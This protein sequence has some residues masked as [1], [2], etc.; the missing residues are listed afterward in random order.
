MKDI[1]VWSEELSKVK[2]FHCND[3]KRVIAGLRDEGAS[4]DQIN[5]FI[6]K[7]KNSDHEVFKRIQIILPSAPKK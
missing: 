7:F 3:I 4:D 2:G 1:N 5:D 6:S